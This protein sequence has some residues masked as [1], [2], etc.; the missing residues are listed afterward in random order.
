M[1]D[2]I[3]N[4]QVANAGHDLSIFQ[5]LTWARCEAVPASVFER[6]TAQYGYELVPKDDAHRHLRDICSQM[7]WDGEPLQDG[8]E[9]IHRERHGTY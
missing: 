2:W 8:H 9:S 4:D 6:E 7:G 5:R 1:N 3:S